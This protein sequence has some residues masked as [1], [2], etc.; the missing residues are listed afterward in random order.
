VLIVDDHGAFRAAAAAM[1]G[2]GGF[3]PLQGVASGEEALAAVAA[4][5][6]GLV[7]L[8][9]QLP[10]MDG[11]TAAELLAAFPRPPAVVLTSSRESAARDPRVLGAPVAGFIAKR[12]LTAAALAAMLR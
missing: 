2:A 4:S 9:L 6:P 11:V 12:D 7:L 1:L 8:D 10:G 3:G 5:S